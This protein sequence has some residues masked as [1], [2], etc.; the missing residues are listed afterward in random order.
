MFERHGR[1]SQT[2]PIGPFATECHTESVRILSGKPSQL[3]R[4]EGFYVQKSVMPRHRGRC[5]IGFEKGG[6]YYR[7]ALVPGHSVAI[8]IARSSLFG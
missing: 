1:L 2:G 3:A 4:F 5:Q 8:C 7:G 6:C